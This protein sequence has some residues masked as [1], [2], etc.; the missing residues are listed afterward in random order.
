MKPTPPKSLKAKLTDGSV[1]LHI[2]KFS[3]PAL[4]A[5]FTSLAFNFVDTFFIAKLGT[6]Y[7]AA[8]TF[9]LPLA[10]TI[11]T[12]T[13]GLGTGTVAVIARVVGE[14]NLSKIKRLNT[15]SLLLSLSVG[16]LIT[17]AIRVTIEPL[18]TVIGAQPEL[19]PLIRDYVDIWHLGIT[20][21]FASVMASSAIR[22]SGNPIFPTMVMI[23]ANLINIVLDPFLVFG[24]GVFPRLEIRGAAIATIIAQSITLLASLIYLNR[25]RMLSFTL[26][27]FKQV[28]KSW[29]SVLH[30][31]IPSAITN[32]VK[33]L[34]AGII[35]RMVSL[36]GPMAIAGFGVVWRLEALATVVFIALSSSMVPI[37]GQNWG[38]GRLDRVNRAFDIG[39]RFCLIWGIMIAIIL[40]FVSPLIASRFSDNPEVISFV[41]TYMRIVP[42]S[43]AAAGII[44]ISSSTFNALAMPMKSALLSIGREFFFYVPLAV[45]G[46]QFFGLNAIFAAACLANL[47]F[48]LVAMLWNRKTLQFMNLEILTVAKSVSISTPTNLTGD[49]LPPNSI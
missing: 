48:G 13:M 8:I 25:N 10:L 11:T 34:T 4:V 44:A 20:I 35:T 1:G 2:V 45:I 24:W 23:L 40:T 30:I 36:Y 49:R 33:P 28:T 47:F 12:L 39:F 42:I 6:N 38:A 26:P 9:T 19:I 15:N 29:Q 18:L 31:A 37:I 16:I 22:A 14:G 46:S 21:I 5:I 32:L 27:K 3:V 17:I 41:A 43:Y 7:L